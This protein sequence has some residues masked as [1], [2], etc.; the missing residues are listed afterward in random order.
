MEMSLCLVSLRC[1]F[2][3]MEKDEEALTSASLEIRISNKLREKVPTE[4]SHV[5]CVCVCVLVG[6][7]GIFL[8]FT[9]EPSQTSSCS[10]GV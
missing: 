6:L 1:L 10:T 9:F 3:L 7:R 4:A 8:F 2:W 5:L